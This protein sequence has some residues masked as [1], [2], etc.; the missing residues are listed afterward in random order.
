VR[1]AFFRNKL[2]GR[3]GRRRVERREDEMNALREKDEGEE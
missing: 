2:I 1:R 3:T